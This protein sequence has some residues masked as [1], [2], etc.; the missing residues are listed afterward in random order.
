M[1]IE[2]K[3]VVGSDQVQ[4]GMK[5]LKQYH[6]LNEPVK[7]IN[8]ARQPRE[9]TPTF[10]LV[11]TEDEEMVSDAEANIIKIEDII[12]ILNQDASLMKDP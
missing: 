10:D 8:V 7:P 5:N 4:K 6:K 1:N 12:R 3:L 11:D 9:E 2:Q